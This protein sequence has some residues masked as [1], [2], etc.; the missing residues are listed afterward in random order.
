MTSTPHVL[1][2]PPWEHKT[3]ASRTGRT[4]S[5]TPIEAPDGLVFA[6]GERERWIDR[7]EDYKT[8]TCYDG[9]CRECKDAKKRLGYHEHSR[10]F[11]EHHLRP[12]ASAPKLEWLALA[13][14]PKDLV[15]E[16]WCAC[17]DDALKRYQLAKGCNGYWWYTDAL[18][19][20][21]AQHGEVMLP[22]FVRIQE[23]QLGSPNFASL[24]GPTDGT[25]A[26]RIAL[27]LMSHGKKLRTRAEVWANH[28]PRSAALVGIPLALSKDKK[29]AELAI[30]LLRLLIVKGHRAVIDDVARAYEASSK[31]HVLGALEAVLGFDP[32][33]YFPAKLP[34]L[35]TFF[36]PEILP[37]I[38]LRSGGELGVEATQRLGMMLAFSRLDLPYAGLAEVK[39]ACTSDSLRELSWAIFQAWLATGAPPKEG[40]AL[41]QL[42]HLG[43][44]EIVRRLSPLV[45]AWPGERAAARAVVGLE[46]IGAIGSE[47]ALMTLNAIADKARFASIKEAATELMN[48]VAADR[49]LSRD[50]LADRLVPDLGLDAS[51]RVK[52]DFGARQ[53]EV[54][55]D[56][57]L[58]PIVR[59]AN[60][61]VLADLPKP[62][63]TDDAAKAK[64]ALAAFKALKKDV[65]SVAATCIARMEMAMLTRRR[66]SEPELRMLWLG[67]PLLRVLARRVVWGEYGE[68][69]APLRLFCITEE[70]TLADDADRPMTL[71]SGAHVGIPHPLDLDP[72]SLAAVAQRLAEYEILQP[73]EQLSRSVFSAAPMELHATSFESLHGI[74]LPAPT[75]VF[76]LEQ[77]GWRRGRAWDGGSF[78]EHTKRFG[79]VT[80]VVHYSG[81]VGMGYID[82]SEK[83]V[84]ERVGFERPARLDTIDPI[85]LSEVLRDVRHLETPA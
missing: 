31:A 44:D 73:F 84:L 29:S 40:W 70:G 52:L 79:E 8:F 66:W 54:G 15:V 55:F 34:K 51:G 45:R 5:L 58:R 21:V 53:F 23:L 6:S 60:G 12:K 43:D 18:A 74:T 25:R 47:L 9:D 64:E 26:G 80:A 83:L 42:G 46:A 61:Q 38:A 7:L 39:A 28:H 36:E 3:K 81:A 63:S 24:L 37:R 19:G 20:A 62:K 68:R 49:G 82:A 32:L 10:A 41:L 77:R 56:E 75:L 33:M 67:K 30:E 57:A 69:R 59:D 13:F 14:G 27:S 35:P 65:K 78:S 2:S 85:I 17:D 22:S 4:L 16:A 76:G 71:G 11:F 50:D 1:S 48:R 72:R